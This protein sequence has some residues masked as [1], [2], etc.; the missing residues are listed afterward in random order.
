MTADK[1]QNKEKLSDWLALQRTKMANHRTLLA[2]LRTGFY[3]L[4]MGLTV[5]TVNNLGE[6]RKY[7]WLFFVVGTL[8]II[9]GIGYFFFN[10]NLLN[11]KYKEALSNEE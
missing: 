11:K 8:F 6:L 7:Y 3:F 10:R 4:V 9:V 5:V 1:P 2:M